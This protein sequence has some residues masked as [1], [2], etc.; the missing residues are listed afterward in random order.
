MV[1]NLLKYLNAPL[2]IPKVFD[3]RST[4]TISSVEAA[5]NG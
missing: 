1:D 2:A 5:V 3:K 4:L